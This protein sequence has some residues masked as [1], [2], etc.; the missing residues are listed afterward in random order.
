MIDSCRS[1]GSDTLQQVIDLGNQPLAEWFPTADELESPEPTWPLRVVVCLKCWLVQ[2][3]QRAAPEL[4]HVL[5]DPFDASET[6]RAHARGLIDDVIRTCALP[7]DATVVE[8]ASHGGHIHRFLA[9]RGLSAVVLE[10]DAQIAERARTEGSVALQ[11]QL[12]RDPIELVEL[13]GRKVDLLIDVFLLAHM[14]ELDPFLRDA[15]A[16]LAPGGTFMLQFDHLLP[17]VS[18]GRYDSFRHGH[19]TYLSLTTLKRSLERH[20]LTP[21]RASR[22]DVYG[23]I[24]RVV[25]RRAEDHPDID[26]SVEAV[27]D[28]ERDAGLE[29]SETLA[30]LQERAVESR[31]RLRALVS[32]ARRAGRAVVAYGAPSRGNTLLNFAGL[33]VEDLPYTVDISVAKQGRFMPGS[34]LPIHP[35]TR[36]METRPD[37]ILILPWDL[38]SEIEEALGFVAEWGGKFLLPLPDVSVEDA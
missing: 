26:P 32:G 35:P 25:V 22:H 2:L 31:S 27:L 34:R 8:V 20:G 19:Y 33:T 38:R 15:A 18:I 6:M 29:S 24:L 17:L 4:P 14:P 23:G 9:E 11:L 37:Y 28:Q 10:P 21:V 30:S 16:L 13:L 5:A 3:D 1:C 36:I 7:G 12:G